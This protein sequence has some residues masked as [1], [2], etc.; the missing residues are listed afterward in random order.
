M[1]EQ[2][3]IQTGD[4]NDRAIGLWLLGVA[5]LVF[6]MIVVGGATRLTESGLSM[7]DW[8]PISGILPPMGPDEWQTEFEAY[9]A[10]PEFRLKN[11]TMTLEEF[12]GIFYWEYG[13]RILGRLIGFAFALPLLFFI[14]RRWVRTDLKLTLFSLLVLGGSQGLLGWYMVQSGLIYEPDVSHY[15][16]AAHLGLA[17]FIL[18]ALMWVG[19][20]LL[21]PEPMTDPGADHGKFRGLVMGFTALVFLQ[22][23]LGAFVAGLDAGRIYN[24][25]PLM[26]GRFAPEGLFYLV[27]WWLNFFENL[28][29]VQFDHRLLAYGLLIFAGG[30]MVAA[31]RYHLPR[32]V[33]RH[34]H[35]LMAVLML[36]VLLGI[37][38]LVYMVPV[39]LGTLHQAGGAL[40]L[41]VAV[42]LSHAIRKTDE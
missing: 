24:S 22:A 38:T 3:F 4:R 19:L 35:V 34:T 20:G 14:A 40:L 5:F 7:T 6:L 33:R 15:R 18:G 26:D 13:H 11:P 28:A 37:L 1:A 17:L 25:W 23:I 27:P 42:G 39:T 32:T 9:Q 21:R 10:Y 36:Q 16:L 8:Q 31:R 29:T 12:K 30:L 41:V 2:S